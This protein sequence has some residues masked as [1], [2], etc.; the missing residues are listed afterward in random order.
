MGQAQTPWGHGHHVQFYESPTRLAKRVADY[1]RDALADGGGGV[2]VARASHIEPIVSELQREGFEVDRLVSGGRLHLIDADALLTGLLVEGRVDREQFQNVIGATV[3]GACANR[4]HVYGELV[5]ILWAAGKEVAV[6][7]L[8][9][10]WAELQEELPF[11]LLCGYRLESFQRDTAAFDRVVACH[12][13]ATGTHR[14]AVL[15]EDVSNARTLAELEQ[16]AHALQFEIDRRTRVEALMSQLLGIT[17]ELA[18]ACT[19]DQIARIAIDR[20]SRS[21]GAASTALWTITPDGT[22][23]ELLGTTENG[24]EVLTSR[25]QRLPVESDTPIAISVR[26]NTSIFLGSLGEYRER[27]PASFA[28]VEHMMSSSHLAFAMIPLGIGDASVGALCFTYAY[29][30]WKFDEAGR[31]FKTILARHLALALERVEL[32]DRERTQRLAAEQA[33]LAEKQARIELAHAYREEQYARMLADEA[34][35]AR[36][37]IISVVSHD[38][39]NPLGTMMI[40]AETLVNV[41]AGD[42][43]ERVRVTAHRIHRDATRMARLIDDL[44]DFAGIQ[45]GNLALQRGV[46]AAERILSATCEIFE[47]IANDRGLKLATEV[48]PDLPPVRCDSNRAVQILS[49]LVTN[50]LRVTPRG[51]E[52]AI[53]AQPTDKDVLF[54]VR[55]T[56]PGIEPEDLPNL[57][58]RYWRAKDT[59]YKG[60]G[61]GLSIARGIVDAHGGRIW[62]ESTVGTGSVFYFSLSPQN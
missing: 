11:S 8:E 17:S 35:R 3:R 2:V 38:L 52:I 43:T 9:G 32:L 45:A 12:D 24:S 60:A 55:D 29:P 41:D 14:V 34:T 62:A 56:G 19:R 10:L 5:D 51:G 6:F 30:R 1:L 27:F 59:S 22:S 57:F 58:E 42:R 13:T 61:L 39:R 16:R 7:E 54:Y 25:Y 33:A 44:V 18:A 26:T 46:H 53:G 49:S 50:A 36:E 47:Q 37:E 31:N 21:L 48:R 28:R 15:D 20:A 23:L 4:L 40:G